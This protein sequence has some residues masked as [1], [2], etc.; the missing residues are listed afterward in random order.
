LI[1]KSLHIV[2]FDI[3]YP[4]IY[5]GI[6]DV[7]YKIKAL[8]ELGVSIHLHTFIYGKEK[9]P[10]LENYCEK[11]HYYKRDFYSKEQVE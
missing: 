2:S 11:V 7:F 4:P 6:I 5:G 1:H 8:K 10:E 3:P 9:Q